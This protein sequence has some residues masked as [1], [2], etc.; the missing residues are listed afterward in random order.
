MPQPSIDSLPRLLRDDLHALAVTL[1]RVAAD[2]FR[3]FLVYGSAVR[4]GFREDK[5]DVNLMLVLARATL[6]EL[7]LV[8][9][10]LALAR[11]Q[12]RIETMVVTADEIQR[13]ADVFPLFY[14]EV[15]EEHVVLAGADPFA[16]LEI[17]PAHRRL[18]IEQELRNVQIRLRRSYVDAGGDERLVRIQTARALRQIRHP[19]RA[20]LQLAGHAITARDLDTV[21]TKAGR[22]LKVDVLPLS[23]IER[24]P[25]AAEQALFSLLARAVEAVD[26]H[27]ARPGEVAT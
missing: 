6:A 9:E 3:C 4:G 27:E 11:M 19:L 15:K 22:V 18:R 10:P 14:E 23:R 5:S 12:H 24:E 17:S 20:F 26:A 25:A 13:A 7:D 1:Q 2:A 21:V 16:K 8:R